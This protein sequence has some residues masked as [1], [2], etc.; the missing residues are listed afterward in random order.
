MSQVPAKYL[1]DENNNIITPI[2]SYKSTIITK[3]LTLYGYIKHQE[4]IPI[5]TKPIYVS[6]GGLEFGHNSWVDLCNTFYWGYSMPNQDSI[7][8]LPGFK[9]Y[10][11]MKAT[12]TDNVQGDRYPIGAVV[13]SFNPDGS[14]QGIDWPFSATWG[15][16][17]D[18]ATKLS[19]NERPISELPQTHCRFKIIIH[20]TAP[21][22]AIGRLYQLDMEFIDRLTV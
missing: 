17:V 2:T 22:D 7:P 11:R 18:R 10:V 6:Q 12:I 4:E 20:G 5:M 16:T 13:G 15:S 14:Y 19:N 21:T 3:D 8:V 1:K 9:R